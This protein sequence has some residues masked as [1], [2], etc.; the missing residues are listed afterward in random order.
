MRSLVAQRAA[1]RAVTRLSAPAA[2]AA[3][4]VLAGGCGSG[5]EDA[6]S[7]MTKSAFVK[8]ATSICKAEARKRDRAL[9]ALNEKLKKPTETIS[10]AEDRKYIVTVVIPTVEETARKI[11]KLDP[12][13]DD[14][15]EVRDFIR[16]L[17]KGAP[18]LAKNAFDP[19]FVRGLKMM[20]RYGVQC[21]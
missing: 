7:S 21:H 12:P 13:A 10:N 8:R 1:R 19:H 2:L 3:L 16:A 6:T 17:E 11:S 9:E 18:G 4:I 14:E 15:N 20:E 5:G